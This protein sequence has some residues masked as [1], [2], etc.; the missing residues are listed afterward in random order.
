MMNLGVSR[1]R[2]HVEEYIETRRS[3]EVLRQLARHHRPRVR[4]VVAT[5]DAD[6]SAGSGTALPA[7][8]LHAA[9]G[10]EE[11]TESVVDLRWPNGFIRA[12]HHYP[13]RA[14]HPSP[15]S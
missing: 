8:A 4:R 1:G 10:G 11:K 6:P 12:Q 14:L 5:A 15:L 7:H 2:R 13:C 3:R 9:C